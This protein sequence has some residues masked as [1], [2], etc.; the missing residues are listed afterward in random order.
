MKVQMTHTKTKASI[1]NLATSKKITY[2]SVNEAKRESTKIQLA[3]GG[4]GAGAVG[5]VK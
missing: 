4:L 5:V 1:I 3:N 2:K